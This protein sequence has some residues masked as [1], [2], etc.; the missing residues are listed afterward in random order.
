MGK[1]REKVAS[2][3]REEAAGGSRGQVAGGQEMWQV[4][5]GRKKCSLSRED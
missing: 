2:E 1:V 5:D 4:E 3:K